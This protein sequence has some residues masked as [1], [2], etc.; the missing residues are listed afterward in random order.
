MVV[1]LDPRGSHGHEVDS[2]EGSDIEIGDDDLD[3][4]MSMGK[5]TPRDSDGKVLKGAFSGK[6]A[7]G[8]MMY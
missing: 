8:W 1:S 7:D 4:H 3:V 2:S 5:K 6:K